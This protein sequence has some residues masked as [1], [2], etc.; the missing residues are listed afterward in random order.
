MSPRNRRLASL[1]LLGGLAL[2]M[3]GQFYFAKRRD[4]IWD[5]VFLYGL[6][7][8][9]FLLA[10]RLT[11]PAPSPQERLGKL[12]WR[13]VSEWIFQHPWR[14]LLVATSAAVAVGV[15]ARATRPLTSGQGYTL[16]GLW[17]VGL[18]LYVGA[19][20]Q[21][22]AA[23]AW[24]AGLPGRARGARWELTIVL[25]LL[26]AAAVARL[27]SLER[28]PFVLGGDEASM[29]LEAVAVLEGRLTNPFATG[30][31][32]HPN[33]FF[34]VLAGAIGLLGPTITGLRLAP[35]LAGALTVPALYLLARE[36]FGRRVAVI[37]AVYLAVYHYAIHYS[38]LGLN[39]AVDP[40]LAV[41]TFY[42]L[43]VGLR[44]RRPAWF[45][46]AGVS[47]GLEQY[48]YIGSRVMPLVLVALVGWLAWR[49][50][51]FWPTYRQQL[52]I[53]AG[54]FLVTG[55]PLFVFFA[56]HPNDFM[57]RVTQ[58]GIIQSGWLAREAERLQRSQVSLLWQQFAKTAL[59]FHFYPDPAPFYRPGQPLLDFV[60]AV[61]FTF[62]LAYS[63]TR[64]RERRHALL[65]LWFWA[66]L[67]FGGMLL[68][69]PPSSQRLVLT[70]VPASVFLALGLVQIADVAERAFRWQRSST[71]LALGLVVALLAAVSVRFYFWA[72]TPSRVYAGFNTYVAHEMGL[73]L[74][75]LG[76]GCRYYFLGAP[77]MYAGFPSIP[78]LAPGVEGH[79]VLEPLT[80]PP[81]FVETDRR[82]VFLFLPERLKEL[83]AVRLAYPA[84]QL[85]EFRQPSGSL[86]FAAYEPSE[87]PDETHR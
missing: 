64:L 1:C 36:L 37:S 52:L 66:V 17:L 44:S 13:L 14:V 82:P 10:V 83:E 26:A 54:A 46:L 67:V 62:G 53:L 87:V 59:A 35:A 16:L 32:S 74:R 42:F 69:N 4:Y 9:L 70:A 8:A 78:Y 58:L 21:L 81:A 19:T 71:W 40:L 48:F 55:W 5:G 15:G 68:E 47:L 43:C 27:V 75:S 51:A 2:A 30:W 49:E 84:G 25:S 50:R 73:Y 33:L 56:R 77:R 18:L 80:G 76:P 38:R 3:V 7:V 85:R 29:G 11:H 45:A 28:I 24:L 31:L 65:V 23:Q 39:N 63:A 34:Y 86:L 72:Y 6:A 20:V 79:D 22:R 41:L 12:R 61:P 60:S 57:A